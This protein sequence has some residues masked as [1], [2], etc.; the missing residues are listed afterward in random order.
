MADEK[1]GTKGRIGAVDEIV[2]LRSAAC[3]WRLS[4]GDVAVFAVILQHCD[5]DWYGFPGPSR[6]GSL[7]RLAVTNV[8]A[9]LRHLE[10]SGYIEVLRSVRGAKNAYRVNDATSIKVP[11]RPTRDAR[12][13]TNRGDASSIHSDASSIHIATRDAGMQQPGMQ[14]AKTRY[15]G[16]RKPGMRT[17]HEG[18]FFKAYEDASE[19]TWATA[20][21][22]SIIEKQ[23]RS[24]RQQPQQ[25]ERK[26]E[27]DRVPVDKLSLD[28]GHA[29]KQELD[30][31]EQQRLSEER[32]QEEQRAG[33]IHDLA[34][35]MY[36]KAKSAGNSAMMQNI[37][38][39]HSESVKDLI[40]ERAA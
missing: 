12:I 10:A 33:R 13:P 36:Q 17:R 8:K 28:A 27:R 2:L 40:E 1:P 4:R 18:S 23:E 6:I 30:G 19:S 20:S 16:V 32:L 21:P 3:D 34:R 14:I 5:A 24:S 39:N 9:S 25:P 7:A 29:S 35:S 11:A 15:A 31:K 26:Q 22:V 38:Q 37:E